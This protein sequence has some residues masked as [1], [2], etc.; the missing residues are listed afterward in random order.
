VPLLRKGKL[1]G[2]A[3]IQ[4]LAF[5]ELG[6][7]LCAPQLGRCGGRAQH[8][9]ERRGAQPLPFVGQA[10]VDKHTPRRQHLG[11]FLVVRSLALGQ[12]QSAVIVVDVHRGGLARAQSAGRYGQES[13]GTGPEAGIQSKEAESTPQ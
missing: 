7:G 9:L 10:L 8:V 3:G 13:H 1:L 11:Q 6:L 12:Q 4:E 5:P 2:E